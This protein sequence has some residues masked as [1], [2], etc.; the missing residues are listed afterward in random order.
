MCELNTGVW[1]FHQE[2]MKSASVMIITIPNNPTSFYSIH[3]K[4]EGQLRWLPC[5][6]RLCLTAKSVKY[7]T[8]S[9]HTSLIFIRYYMV[10]IN[11][12]C[13]I[14]QYEESLVINELWN[15]AAVC[16]IDTRSRL[17]SWEM[18]NNELLRQDLIK[19]EEKIWSN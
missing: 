8:L 17:T 18:N 1:R 5:L 3:Q 11:Y 13:V 7:I 6:W 15:L 16:M 4:D 9:F 12:S 10:W 2:W 19:K 14:S